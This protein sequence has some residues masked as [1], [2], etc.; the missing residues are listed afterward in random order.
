MEKIYGKSLAAAGLYDIHK[1]S[2]NT[3]KMRQWRRS[4]FKNLTLFML[5]IY[6]APF[7]MAYYAV[8]YRRLI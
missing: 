7:I 8:K 1:T 2:H 4:Y 6:G 3:E 5:C